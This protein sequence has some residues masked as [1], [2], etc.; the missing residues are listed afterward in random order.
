MSS[1]TFLQLV[2]RLAQEAG[3]T[4]NASAV[5][6]VTGQ[7][8]EALRLVNWVKQS[9]TE[10]QTR[11]ENWRWMRSTF[12]VNTVV[13]D[14]TY[15]YSDC[16]DTRLTGA[17][18]RF[19]QWIPFDD[20]GASNIKRYLTSGGVGGEMWMTN[21]PWSYFRSI[22][23]LGTQ[24][25]GPSLHVTIDPQNNLVFGP[26]PDAIYTVSGEY[27]MSAL[28]FSADGDIPEFPARFHDLVW[29]KALE[30]YGRYHA[31]GEVL[32]RGQVEGGRVMAQLEADQLPDIAMGAPIA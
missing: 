26:K 19:G 29:M 17:I 14:D 31:A 7:S 21:L 11:S 30:K 15:A 9:H 4:G 5:S 32:A 28:E 2:N 24:N 10:I 3:V 22:Y 12:S 20:Q 8:G 16:T 6:A 25:N 13:A 23:R 18:S 1:Q 27:Q